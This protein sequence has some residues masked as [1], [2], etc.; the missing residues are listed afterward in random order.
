VGTRFL[1]ARSGVRAFQFC[2]LCPVVSRGTTL[3]QEGDE[4]AVVRIGWMITPGQGDTL[5]GKPLTLARGEHGRPQ[6]HNRANDHLALAAIRHGREG[7][8]RGPRRPVGGRQGSSASG[9]WTQMA[10]HYEKIRASCS[11][12]GLN[13]G[14]T[15]RGRN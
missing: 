6:G 5:A 4:P 7:Q 15:L 2:E 9:V 1:I 14:C 12:S 3:S 8:G 10:T 13:Q 11:P